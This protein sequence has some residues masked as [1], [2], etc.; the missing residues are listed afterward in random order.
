MRVLI[1]WLFG[2]LAMFTNWCPGN[3]EWLV[4]RGLVSSF[5]RKRRSAHT[6]NTNLYIEFLRN[7]S[8]DETAHSLSRHEITSF[9]RERKIR[10]TPPLTLNFL[11]H[12]DKPVRENET[13]KWLEKFI[14]MPTKGL[15]VRKYSSREKFWMHTIRNTWETVQISIY[16][17]LKDSA[18]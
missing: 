5:L 17:L 11:I 2:I 16:L 4:L 1:W 8:S 18:V 15:V 13:S 14:R 9:P 6:I 12:L 7:R 3:D 10:P